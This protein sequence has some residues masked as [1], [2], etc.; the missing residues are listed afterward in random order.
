MSLPPILFDMILKIESRLIF[1]F[2][3]W[4]I[5]VTRSPVRIINPFAFFSFKKIELL[6]RQLLFRF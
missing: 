4:S 6:F 2:F 5:I 3:N 1:F